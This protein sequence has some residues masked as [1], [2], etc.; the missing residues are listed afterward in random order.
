MK[1]AKVYMNIAAC[2]VALSLCLQGVCSSEF[3]VRHIGGIH[4]PNSR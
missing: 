3:Y 2:K 1:N 4:P